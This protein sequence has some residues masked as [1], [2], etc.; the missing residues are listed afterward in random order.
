MPAGLQLPAV[1]CDGEGRHW[2]AGADVP[3]WTGQG[4]LKS[5]LQLVAGGGRQGGIADRC[6]SVMAMPQVPPTRCFD[7]HLSGKVPA[8]RV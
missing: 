3:V 2:E 7:P 1:L 5:Q 4:R 6:R 8:K